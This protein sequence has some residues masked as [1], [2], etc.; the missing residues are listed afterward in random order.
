M[1]SNQNI[2][3]KQQKNK[4]QKSNQ[5]ERGE[6]ERGRREV[7]GEPILVVASVLQAAQVLPQQLH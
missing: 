3:N 7:A 1:T 4:T 2:E 6:R 5:R